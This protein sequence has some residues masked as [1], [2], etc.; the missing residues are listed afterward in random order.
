MNE[1]IE[2]LTKA[3]QEANETR[4]KLN[5]LRGCYMNVCQAFH[6]FGRILSVQDHKSKNWKECEHSACK[7]NYEVLVRLGLV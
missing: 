3:N 2:L 1:S 7:L 5:T 6:E 4:I